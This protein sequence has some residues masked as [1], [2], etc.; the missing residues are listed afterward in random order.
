LRF[1]KKIVDG[2]FLERPNRY[3]ARVVVEG[4]EILAHI[5]DPGR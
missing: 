1:G 3:L 4:Q 5:P 2:V